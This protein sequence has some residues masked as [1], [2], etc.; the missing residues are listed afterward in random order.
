[1]KKVYAL[2]ILLLITSLILSLPN[3]LAQS[4]RIYELVHPSHM[5]AGSQDPIE[6]K[7]IVYYNDTSPGST[8]D[9][10][11]LD[12]HMTPSGII[13]AIVTSSPDT[14]LNQGMLAALCDIGVKT[15]SGAESLDFKIGGIL[16]EK[17][18]PGT[19]DLNMTTALYDSSNTL[20]PKSVNT[21]LFGISLT[22]VAL[23]VNVPPAVVVTVDGVPQPPGPAIV[24]VALGAHKIMVPSFVQ[25]DPGTRLLFDHWPDGSTDA[26]KT[27]FITGDANFDLV[28]STQHL[29]TIVD[30]QATARGAGWYNEGQAA[31]FSVASIEHMDG[32]LGA[33]GGKLNFQG[34]YENGQLLTTL[35]SGTVVMNQPRTITA[36][37]Q[38]DY[39]EPAIVLA[40][41]IIAVAFAYLLVRRRTTK[42]PGR[43]P[44]RRGRVKRKS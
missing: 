6:V 42:T 12:M 28:Y 33:L 13:P 20:I 1:L 11:I 4:T 10:R 41:I 36:V 27:I 3:T 31:T 18:G 9:V 43:R 34:W 26:N 7:A 40:G 19:W 29:L 35:T 38:P 30:P 25:V 15:A 14:C 17:R 39:S 23:K 37:F 16:D 5:V 22:P 8:L 44:R 2:L 24:G 21:V 32:I